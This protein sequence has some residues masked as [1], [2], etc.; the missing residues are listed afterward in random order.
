MCAHP[1][2]PLRRYWSPRGR[3][4]SVWPSSKSASHVVAALSHLCLNSSKNQATL[5]VK[6]CPP[7]AVLRHH[8]LEVPGTRC[9]PEDPF[10]WVFSSIP[11]TPGPRGLSG[12]QTG[13]DKSSAWLGFPQWVLNQRFLRTWT[14]IPTQG[15]L[16]TAH[17]SQRCPS[18]RD[19]PLSF[20]RSLP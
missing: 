4:G 15:Y 17:Q 13:T 20:T 14:V 9:L 3:L 19:S 16:F 11:L 12:S 10:P 5:E 1:D 18:H 8:Y 6:P 2:P 7:F